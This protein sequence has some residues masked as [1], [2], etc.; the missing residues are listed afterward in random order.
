MCKHTPGPWDYGTVLSNE[1]RYYQ[2]IYSKA[3]RPLGVIYG[4][5]NHNWTN[6]DRANVQLVTAAPK[7]LAAAE[8]ALALLL[9][10]QD[11]QEGPLPMPWPEI[12]AL[13]DAIKSTEDK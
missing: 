4:D 6:E 7:L 13:E 3:G 11:E 10:I 12:Q 1:T 8:Q 2:G 5:A 9:T